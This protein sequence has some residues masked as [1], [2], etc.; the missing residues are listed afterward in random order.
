MLITGA[1]G[2]GKSALGLQLMAFGCDL[3]ADDQTILTLHDNTVWAACPAPLADMIEARFVGIVGATAKLS[4]WVALAINMDATEFDR[5]PPERHL[6]LFGCKIPL[7]HKVDK[8]YF[9]AAVLQY[10]RSG[11]RLP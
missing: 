5:M 6:E 1:S 10:L 4:A 9:P 7:L 2:T 3:V 11:L 8:A